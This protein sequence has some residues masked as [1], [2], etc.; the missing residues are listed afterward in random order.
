MVVGAAPALIGLAAVPA[1]TEM[2]VTVF[3]LQLS[4]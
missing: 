3:E 1:A 2:G 4:T